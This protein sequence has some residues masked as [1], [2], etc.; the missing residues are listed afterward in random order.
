MFLWWLVTYQYNFKKKG[1]KEW[2]YSAASLCAKNLM[3]I[4]VKVE[5]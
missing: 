5:A 3:Q 1:I 2:L 4:F